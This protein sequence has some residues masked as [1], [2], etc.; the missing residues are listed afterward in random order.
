MNCNL[1]ARRGVSRAIWL[2][3]LAAA[4]DA[5]DRLAKRLGESFLGGPDLILVQAQIDAM[6]REVAL[7]RR[8]K[9]AACDQVHPEWMN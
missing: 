3:E 4:L 5:A 8:G 2:S 7:L 9:S 6:A 1:M